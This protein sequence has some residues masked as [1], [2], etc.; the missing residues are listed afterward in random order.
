MTRVDNERSTRAW[1]LLEIYRERYSIDHLLEEV[2]SLERSITRR[3]QRHHAIRRRSSEL[4]MQLSAARAELGAIADEIAGSRTAGALLIEDILDRVRQAND[5]RWSPRP[6]RGYRVWRIE[7]GAIWGNQV[8]WPEPR[9]EGRCLRSIPGDDIPHSSGRCGP[10]ACG[11]YAVKDLDMFPDSVARCEMRDTAVGVVAL[12]GKVIEHELG[13][14]ARHAS[15][16]ALAIRHRGRRVVT[17]RLSDI[18]SLF[19]SPTDAITRLEEDVVSGPDEA[20][21][22]LE[23]SQKED[24]WT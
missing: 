1:E 20:R 19:R 12:T 18:E 10:P 7:S 23:T 15:V 22:F 24:T 16:V 17:S 4:E 9:L 13:Y 3:E 6:L 8:T 5:E 14:R 11:V 21:A 2:D